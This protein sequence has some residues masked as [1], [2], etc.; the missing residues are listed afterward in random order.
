MGTDTERQGISLKCKTAPAA[1]P[2][3]VESSTCMLLQQ[4]T[5]QNNIVPAGRYSP[6]KEHQKGY[7]CKTLTIVSQLLHQFSLQPSP[8]DRQLECPKAH[9]AGRYAAHYSPWLKL[10]IPV[11]E[12][13][14]QDLITCA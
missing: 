8:A 5:H 7:A 9:K 6:C 4:S 12:H 2:T 3:I 13:V 10:C 1:R 11:I 14:T